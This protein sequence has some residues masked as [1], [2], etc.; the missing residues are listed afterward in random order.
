MHG[1]FP[2]SSKSRLGA[3]ARRAMLQP[4]R[5]TQRRQRPTARRP[6]PA[7]RCCLCASASLRLRPSALRCTVACVPVPVRAAWAL[8]APSQRGLDAPRNRTFDDASTTC[9]HCSLPASSPGTPLGT[10]RMLASGPSRRAQMPAAVPPP[11]FTPSAC[12]R[13]CN[14]PQ[15]PLRL[16]MPSTHSALTASS[17]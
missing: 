13:L 1:R 12:K 17:S 7:P 14:T 9:A 11:G 8:R 5:S 15:P 3:T 2:D 4:S 6:P 10:Q 16:C